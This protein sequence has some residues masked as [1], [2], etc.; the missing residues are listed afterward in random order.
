M[1][2]P[3]S[4]KDGTLKNGST[5][6]TPIRNWKLSLSAALDPY[7]ANDT[8]GSKKR[9]VGVEDSTGSFEIGVVD[10]GT[11]PFERGDSVTLNLYVGPAANGN[12][13]SVPAIIQGW[14]ID[15]DINDG[16]GVWLS[17][18]YEGDGAITAHGALSKAGDAGSSG[19]I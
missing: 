12:Y 1:G 7:A 4:G 5:E 16:K 15:C 17:V 19:D 18:K 8:G 9:V 13:Y 11:L 2:K 10:G 6:W 14:D 3:L